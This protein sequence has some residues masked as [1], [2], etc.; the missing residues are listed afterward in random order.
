MQQL[1]P[2]Q[3]VLFVAALGAIAFVGYRIVFGHRVHLNHDL[4]VVNVINGDLYEIDT[5]GKGIVLPAKDPATGNR[6]LYP[7]YQDDDGVWH[8]EARALNAVLNKK[9]E[10]D[11]LLDTETGELKK[12]SKKI[13]R[14]NARDLVKR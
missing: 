2:W 7:I 5:N 8:L 14:V 4:M 10:V 6:T 13:H 1:K 12:F 3:I 9:Y 11:T